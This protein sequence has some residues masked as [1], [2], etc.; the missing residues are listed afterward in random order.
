MNLTEVIHHIAEELEKTGF[1][2][3]WVTGTPS[4]QELYH[5]VESHPEIAS[6]SM[7]ATDAEYASILGSEVK[8]PHLTINRVLND[9]HGNGDTIPF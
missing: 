6:Y 1:K 4:R 2:P 9:P 8:L 7:N 3:A 5:Y